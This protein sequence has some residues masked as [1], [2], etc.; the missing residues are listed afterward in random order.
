M[1]KIIE[2]K[3]EL[4]FC[5]ECGKKLGWYDFSLGKCK[6]CH[7]SLDD[8]PKSDTKEEKEDDKEVVWE[9]GYCK[10]EFDKKEECQKHEKECKTK[11]MIKEIKCKCNQCGNVWHYLEE[12]E[13]KLKTQATSNALIGCGMCCNPFGALFSNKAADLQRELDKMKK[14]PKCNSTDVTRTPIY[15]EKRA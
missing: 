11:G 9:C 14:C 8:I 4:I 15:H 3:E 2:R 13:K 12:D 1:T 7:A 5:P 6:K 10:K